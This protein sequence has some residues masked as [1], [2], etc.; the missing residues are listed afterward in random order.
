M[1]PDEASLTTAKININK[2]LKGQW[3]F[4]IDK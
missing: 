3:P 2:I 4:F 1:V